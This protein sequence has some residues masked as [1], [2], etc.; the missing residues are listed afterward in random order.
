MNFALGDICARECVPVLDGVLALFLFFSFLARPTRAHTC[1]L[2][3]KLIKPLDNEITF[4]T[5]TLLSPYL[6]LVGITTRRICFQAHCKHA[7]PRNSGYYQD[8]T[9]GGEIL[10]R[11]DASANANSHPEKSMAATSL[12]KQHCHALRPFE[13]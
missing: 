2:T 8:F 9:L 4:I 6:G 3:S 11:R 10:A 5:V 13:L 7:E 12:G 1:T